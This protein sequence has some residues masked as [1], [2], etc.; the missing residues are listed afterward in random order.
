M[1]H[2]FLLL[3]A[4]AVSLSAESSGAEK[5]KE[6]M[7]GAVEKELTFRDGTKEKMSYPASAIISEQEW[8]SIIPGE[9]LAVRFEKEGDKLVRPKLEKDE[10]KQDDCVR[11]ECAHRDGSLTLS[12]KNPYD[13]Y[14]HYQCGTI[15]HSKDPQERIEG[16]RNLPVMPNLMCFEGYTGKEI[17]LFFKGFLLHDTQEGPKPAATEPAGKRADNDRPTQPQKSDKP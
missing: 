7:R 9:K 16:R 17:I 3:S 15:Q 5:D 14:L 12:I 2:L 4:V 6:P 10:A 8:I 13:K 1:K 11:F